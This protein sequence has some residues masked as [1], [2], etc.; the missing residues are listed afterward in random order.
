MNWEWL[1]RRVSQEHIPATV[2]VRWTSSA[3]KVAKLAKLSMLM[4]FGG[5]MT[6]KVW[7]AGG[8][9]ST[10][11]LLV[12]ANKHTNKR[13]NGV[14][15]LA[16]RHA[17]LRAVDNFYTHYKQVY[18][19]PALGGDHASCGDRAYAGKRERQ[20][21]RLH[22]W[23]GLRISSHHGQFNFMPGTEGCFYV[24]RDLLG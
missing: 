12:G 17:L 20:C 10:I 11:Q 15:G 13:P 4:H 24:Q 19:S 3:R 2:Q 18:C 23:R 9:L 6:R 7:A 14:A 8:S 5:T 1:Q 22:F 16:L 21:I